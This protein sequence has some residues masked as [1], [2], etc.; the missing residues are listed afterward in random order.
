MPE[1]A[2]VAL[3]HPGGGYYTEGGQLKFIEK[4]YREVGHADGGALPAARGWRSSWPAAAKA[5]KRARGVRGVAR[6]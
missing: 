2:D 4:N 5:A 3:E 1:L 6:A